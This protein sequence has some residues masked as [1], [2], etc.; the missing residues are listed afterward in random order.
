MSLLNFGF[1][2]D[3]NEPQPISKRKKEASAKYELKRKRRFCNKWLDDFAWLRY[4]EESETMFCFTCRQHEREG[5]F[6]LGTDNYRIDAVKSH[7]DSTVHHKH[8]CSSRHAASL[9]SATA[10][11]TQSEPAV[12]GPSNAESSDQACQP[13]VIGP[14]DV[15]IRRLNE[16]QKSQLTACFNTA[17]FIA[18]EELPFTLYPSLL[19]LQQK[20][21]VI[22]PNSYRTDQ[23]CRR[24][25]E[26]IYDDIQTESRCLLTNARV[27]S[28]MFDGATDVSVSENEIVYARVVEQG[29]PRNVYVKINSVAHAH[30]EGVLGAI[31]SAMDSVTVEPAWDWKQKLIATGS[32]GANVN[33][34]KRH[35]VAKLLKD[36]VPHLFAMHC[37]SHRLELGAIDAMK[38]RDGKLFADIKSVLMYLHK[39]YHYSPKALRE[40]QLLSDAMEDKMAKPV[41]LSGTRWMPHLSRCLDV[42]LNK[43]CTFVAHFENTLEGR[44]GSA[45]VQGR[46]KLI[47]KHL[48]DYNL[49]HYMHFLKDVLAILSDLSL[50]FQRDSCGLPEATEALE[51]ACLRLTALHQ[52]PGINLQNFLDNVTEDHKFKTVQLHAPTLTVD[53]FKTKQDTLIDLVIDHIG[54]RVGD[55]DSNRLLKCMQIFYPVNLPETVAQRAVYGEDSLN[56]LC[57]YYAV[58]LDR[59][60]CDVAH[61][62]DVEWPLLKVHMNRQRRGISVSELYNRLFT[63]SNLE[64]TMKN[65][66]MLV[67]IVL[68]IP[69]SSAICERGFSTMARVKSDWRSRLDVKMLNCLMAISIQGPQE[70]NPQRALEKWWHGGQRSRRPDFDTN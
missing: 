33:L 6:V 47:L 23:A 53:Q 42:L 45:E 29:V 67:E 52:R 5:R 43:Y 26:Y 63:H 64:E 27:L 31:T 34:G 22:L 17:Y 54:N 41:N 3:K 32:D 7:N 9:P 16:E 19:S 28:I 12:A 61:L 57:L 37:V 68:C 18:K 24:F 8:W 2:S 36:Q 39:H 38:E 21:G 1:S 65:I 30:A 35:S 11:E 70:Y 14:I 62:R 51:A 4:D 58:V 13:A 15:A 59:M 46:A 20:N 25:I 60:G 49:L 55:I 50:Q 44:T 56:E 69:V 48:Q 66:L 10:S 40:L